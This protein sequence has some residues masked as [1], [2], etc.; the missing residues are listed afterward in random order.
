MQSKKK[1]P[2]LNLARPKFHAFPFSTFLEKNL[3]IT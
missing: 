2:L 3:I 1:V